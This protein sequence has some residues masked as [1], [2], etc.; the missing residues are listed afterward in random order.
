[1][2]LDKEG[3]TIV[4][5]IEGRIGEAAGNPL[6]FAMA[7]GLYARGIRPSSRAEISRGS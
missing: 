6:L 4:P 3:A 5:E 7:V 1:M 2:R